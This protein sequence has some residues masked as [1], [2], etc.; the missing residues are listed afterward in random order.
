M[1]KTMV[2][3]QAFPRSL[4]PC[5][6]LAFPSRPK[7]PFLSFSKACHAGYRDRRSCFLLK[8]YAS[9]KMS[10]HVEILTKS[11]PQLTLKNTHTTMGV[12]ICSKFEG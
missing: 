11:L 2:S 7:P 5:G 9:C 10:K 3:W 12:W 6:P 8:V 1:A 4:P